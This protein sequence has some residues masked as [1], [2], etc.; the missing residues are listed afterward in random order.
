MCVFF[1][2]F[3]SFFLFLRLLFGLFLLSFFCCSFFYV[4]FFFVAFFLIYVLGIFFFMCLPRNPVNNLPTT[5]VGPFQTNDSSNQKK[6]KRAR[7]KQRNKI[8]SQLYQKVYDVLL[9]VL[10]FLLLLKKKKLKL[11]C[12]P[13]FFFIMRRQCEGDDDGLGWDSNRPLARPT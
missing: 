1:S 13:F 5:T 11:V 8:K 7:L 3:L 10:F 4:V 2:P 12:C 6:V 9:L